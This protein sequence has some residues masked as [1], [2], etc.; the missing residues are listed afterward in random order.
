[1]RSASRFVGS[2]GSPMR[3]VRWLGPIVL[4]TWL[5][6]MGTSPVLASPAAALGHRGCSNGWNVMASPNEGSFANYLNGV[7][8]LSSTDVWATGEYLVNGLNSAT[9][10]EHWNG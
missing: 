6:S 8:V 10:V 4:V 5:T 7:S 2:L 3:R 1:M 9:L